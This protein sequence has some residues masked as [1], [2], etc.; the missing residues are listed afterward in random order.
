[1][2]NGYPTNEFQMH[3][4]LRRGD[5]LSHFLFI[6]GMDGFHVALVIS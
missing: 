6:L 1:M 4:G 3:R 5:S 2:V